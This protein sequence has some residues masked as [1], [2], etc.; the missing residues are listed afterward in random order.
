MIVKRRWP[1]VGL[2]LM[3]VT[4]HIVVWTGFYWQ[5]L[6]SCDIVGLHWRQINGHIHHLKIRKKEKWGECFKYTL[7]LLNKEC[8]VVVLKVFGQWWN[9]HSEVRGFESIFDPVKMLSPRITWDALLVLFYSIKCFTNVHERS[10]EYTCMLHA[11]FTYYNFMLG[12]LCYELLYS[13]LRLQ[14]IVCSSI[15]YTWRYAFM[16]LIKTHF[17]FCVESSTVYGKNRHRSMIQNHVLILFS[18]T[19]WDLFIVPPVTVPAWYRICLPC[20]GPAN[21]PTSRHTWSQDSSYD[22]V[23]WFSLRLSHSRSKGIWNCCPGLP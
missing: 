20:H 12:N 13:S 21:S 3:R 8:N 1:W 23:C 7:N 6:S 4:F 17:P 19:F 5:I 16:F 11:N 22:P 2:K 15:Y 10:L 14:A 18:K 9:S